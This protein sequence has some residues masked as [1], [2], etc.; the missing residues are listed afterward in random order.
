V[1]LVEGAC[2]ASSNAESCL[3]PAAL[4]KVVVGSPRSPD[5]RH[6]IAATGIGLISMGG[7]KPELWAGERLGNPS[8]LSDCVID[9]SGDHIACIRATKLVLLSKAAVTAQPEP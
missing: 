2:V 5:G 4:G 1:A 9:N 3:K 8:T 6:L 7:P